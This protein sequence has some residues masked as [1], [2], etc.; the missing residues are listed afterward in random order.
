MTRI[1]H[2]VFLFL[3]GAALIQAED[4]V[5]GPDSQRQ[6][7]VPKGTVTQQTFTSKVTSKI[8]PG[9]LRDY[10]IYVPAQYQGDKPA[11]VMVFQDGG[12]MVTE[13]G[14]WRVP[15]VFDNLIHKG[16]MPLTIGIFV[17]PGVLPAAS[18][19]QQ[20]RYNRSYEYD[21]LGYR[22]A[23]FLIEEILPE[24]AKRYN[25]SKDPNPA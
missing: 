8:Y 13:T 21:A 14:S 10:W 23:Q 25:L 6:P 22:Y 17:N 19:N 18:P 11:C 20:S 15:T 2:L 7:G 5:L 16:E 24:V 4:Y 9:T 12:G 1:P 3:T